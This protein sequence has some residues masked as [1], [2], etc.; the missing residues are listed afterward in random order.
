VRALLQTRYVTS[1]VDRASAHFVAAFRECCLGLIDAESGDV[2]SAREA[3][4]RLEALLPTVRSASRAEGMRAANWLALLNA[5]I[6]LADGRPNEAIRCI[7]N[8]FKLWAPSVSPDLFYMNLFSAQDALARAYAAKGD[9]DRAITEYKRFLTFD[10][11]SKDR[12]LLN[13]PYEYRLA[14]LLE[15]SG[16]PIEALEHYTRFL[17]YWK[18]ADPDLPELIDAKARVAA[19][20]RKSG[21]A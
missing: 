10:P 18:D 21:K 4:K 1:E 19:L 9:I 17:E 3:A 2:R 5:E 20:G 6:L 8:D 7:A 13:P 14:K 12:R 16:K 11:A 15:K